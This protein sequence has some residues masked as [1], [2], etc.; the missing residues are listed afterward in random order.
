MMHDFPK[1]IHG[2]LFTITQPHRRLQVQFFDTVF[3]NNIRTV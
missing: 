1:S 2:I 3:E